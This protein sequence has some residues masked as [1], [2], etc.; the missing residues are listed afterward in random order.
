MAENFPSLAELTLLHPSVDI[1]S[2]LTPNKM[3][4]DQMA[5]GSGARV[6]NPL[7]GGEYWKAEGNRDQRPKA[8]RGSITP[9]TEVTHR[10]PHQSERRGDQK[11]LNLRA[12]QLPESHIPKIH[13]RN[14]GRRI[15]GG[16]GRDHWNRGQRIR[17]QLVKTSQKSSPKVGC[18]DHR[19]CRRRPDIGRRSRR[20][21][22][23]FRIRTLRSQ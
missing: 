7:N 6:S 22:K 13:S 17:N 15:R 14:R 16:G 11:L 10:N 3:G 12:K 1:R 9:Q 2:H 8:S 5:R 18:R 23:K 21:R 19:R 20:C 4:R